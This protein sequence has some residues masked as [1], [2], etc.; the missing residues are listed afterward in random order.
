MVVATVR[1]GAPENTE[2]FRPVEGEG[3]LLWVDRSLRFRGEG[4]DLAVGY[5][6]S[7]KVVYATNYISR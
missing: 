2:D 5:A 7:R 6:G 3:F 4:I 1:G